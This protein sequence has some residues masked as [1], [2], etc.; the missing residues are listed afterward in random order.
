MTYDRLVP[1][2]E[3]QLIFNDLATLKLEVVEAYDRKDVGKGIAR[4]NYNVLHSLGI[5]I[6]DII[7]I[8]GKEKATPAMFMPLDSATEKENKYIVGIDRLT[9]YNARV[10][11]GE[12]VTISKTNGIA[13]D[14]ITMKPLTAMAISK[15]L[16]IDER[17]L[18]DALTNVPNRPMDVVVVPYFKI[19]MAFTVIDIIPFNGNYNYVG[20]SASMVSTNTK[21]E[22]IY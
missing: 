5:R 12:F 2:S 7:E 9:R 19:G 4:I 17:Y 3:Q 14:K 15:S 1:R 18:R 16:A 10:A 6:G 13:A 21:F 11:T 20:S 8:S 22:I